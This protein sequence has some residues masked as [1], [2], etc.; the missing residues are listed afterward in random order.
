[1]E[2][3]QSFRCTEIGTGSDFHGIHI[4][5]QYIIGFDSHVNDMPFPMEL[6]ALALIRAVCVYRN[7]IDQQQY[8]EPILF[9]FGLP[10]K[11]EPHR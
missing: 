8:D 11:K 2:V 5:V 10:I 1:M 4:Y 3:R 9:H 6:K 7:C